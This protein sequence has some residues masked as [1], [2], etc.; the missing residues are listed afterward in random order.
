VYYAL[1]IILRIK[2]IDAR[3]IDTTARIGWNLSIRAKPEVYLYR[4]TLY[5]RV[6]VELDDGAETQVRGI[7]G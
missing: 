3:N 5:A 7:E 6:M 1:C 2:L 4:A